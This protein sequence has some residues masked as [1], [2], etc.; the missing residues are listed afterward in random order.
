MTPDSGA[1]PAKL[2]LI[3]FSGDFA[4]VHYALAAAA[5]AAAIDIPATLFFTME[6][7]RAVCTDDAWHALPAG[8]EHADAKACDAAYRAR[9]VAGFEELLEACRALG[10]RI[11]VCTMGL[12]AVALE[13][14]AL[15][16]D[17]GIET[18]GLVTFLND[19][20]AEGSMLFV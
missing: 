2:S 18:G 9:G 11:I 4:K 15:R 7:T 5:A 16:R 1:R 6:A 20:R 17:L 19:A 14:T 8:A 3:V 10:V 12:K 13:E